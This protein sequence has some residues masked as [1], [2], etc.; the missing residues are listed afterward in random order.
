MAR[1]T[2]D[3]V[4]QESILDIKAGLWLCGD[5]MQSAEANGNKKPKGCA[6]GLLVINARLAPVVIVKDEGWD[7]GKY[8]YCPQISN[9]TYYFKMGAPATRL[10]ALKQSL[11]ALA[12]AIPLED[13]PMQ[14][15]S[16]DP[17]TGE[18]EEQEKPM[19]D[20]EIAGL[21]VDELESMVIEYNDSNISSEDAEA[22]FQK[23][24]AIAAK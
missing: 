3:V 17:E 24:Y 10:H 23:A 6:V 4:L 20:K 15:E 8:A 7:S 2:A 12:Q 16:A 1:T 19:T 22:W 11:V 18:M 9:P 5:L 14:F 13:R 21:S